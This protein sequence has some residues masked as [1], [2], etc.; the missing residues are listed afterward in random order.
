MNRILTIIL[1]VVFSVSLMAENKKFVLVI[2]AGHGGH[3][4]GAV[5]AFSKEKTINLNTA[6]AFGRL[7]ESNC[8]DVTVIYTRKKDVF[9][10]LHERADIANKNHADVFIS[11]HTNSLPNGHIARG[12]ET[13]T[14][15]MRRSDEKLSAAQRENSVITIETDYKEHY[16]GYDPKSPES[17]IMFEF[18]HDRNMSKSVELAK[19][20]QKEVC[21]SAGRPNKGVK[22]DV[23][24]VLRETSM[25]ACLLELGFI[26]TPDEENLL[27]DKA[28]IDKFA[29]GI[30]NAFVQYK[31][32]NDHSGKKY[33]TV[34]VEETPKK[35]VPQSSD[36][37]EAST[38]AQKPTVGK[39]VVEEVKPETKAEPK[40][41]EKPAVKV[42]PKKEEKPV[43]KPE[44]KKEEK[45]AVKAEPKTNTNVSA[46]ELAQASKENKPQPEKKVEKQSDKPVYKVQ[47]MTNNKVLRPDSDQFKGVTGASYYRDGSTVKYTLGE[48]DT[49]QEADKIK[50]SISEKFPDAFI[51]SFLGDERIDLSAA[52]KLTNGK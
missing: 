22:Q 20:V 17:A 7:V 32:K 35:N 11:I 28:T 45:P 41:E 6:L 39:A 25:P 14:M 34:R 50:K 2:D 30:Y 26:S 31:N 15:G 47:F 43:V 23:F 49:Y 51:V 10:P 16:A 21:A 19:Y 33:S 18:V 40:K 37:A 38:P 36:I 13:Y 46:A 44:P 29:R 12:V 1:S 5:G 9:I 4:S 48:C 52:R 8:N 42:E 24:L 27:N 3:D